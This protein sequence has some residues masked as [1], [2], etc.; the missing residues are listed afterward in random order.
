TLRSARACRGPN[1]IGTTSARRLGCG[2]GVDQHH[3]P[4]FE[5]FS[6]LAFGYL[7]RHFLAAHAVRN[8]DVLF[9]EAIKQNLKRQNWSSTV[10]L[11]VVI[12][13]CL[14]RVP[15]EVHNSRLVTADPAQTAG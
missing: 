5:G 1:F 14:R 11:R 3:N 12:A 13:V 10:T 15:A 7:G 9:E 2:F 6:A 8:L 4:T